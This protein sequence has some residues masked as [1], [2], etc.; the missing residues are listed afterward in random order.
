MSDTPVTATAAA[1]EAAC[2]HRWA[3]W[4][5][6]TGT[7]WAARTAGL[8]AEQITSGCLPF[9]RGDNPDELDTAIR[10]QDR[11]S[12]PPRGNDPESVTTTHADA[13]HASTPPR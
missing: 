1:L 10:D 12:S 9:L 6:D 5:S 4:I 13:Q 2:D 8:T 11:A 3:V 7:W